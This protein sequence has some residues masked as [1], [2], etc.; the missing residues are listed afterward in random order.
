MPQKWVVRQRQ[1]HQLVRA[2]AGHVFSKEHVTPKQLYG[3]TKL[4][5]ITTSHEGEN[6]KYIERTKIPGLSD[7][8]GTDLNGLSLDDAAIQCARIMGDSRIKQLVRR[9]TG[10]TNF[11][12]AYRNSAYQWFEGN[13]SEIERLFRSA[14]GASNHQD[15]L[16]LASSIEALPRVPKPNSTDGR[17]RPEYILTPV[18]FTLDP[19]LKFPLI[20]GNEWVNNVLCALDVEDSLV[21]EQFSAMAHLI[22]QDGIQDAAE[23]D[24]VG[25]RMPDEVASFI[26][27]KTRKRSKRIL[28]EKPTGNGKPL[29]LKDES[30]VEAIKKAGGIRQRHLHNKM[31]NELRSALGA[32]DI[33]EGESPECMFD[34][35]VKNYDGEGTDLLVEVK[36]ASDTP[37]V[38]MAIGQ[39]YHYWFNLSDASGECHLAVL[40]PSP[41]DVGVLE[42][43][44]NLDIGFL[45]IND[46][47][48]TTKS[49]WL[50][51]LVDEVS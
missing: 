22:G 25:R 3:I 2:I 32:Y 5:W 44:E 6:P 46:G 34:V 13:H 43:L 15:R 40:L 37:H 47:C 26:Q 1:T 51:H 29:P 23:L 45:C 33:L 39:L 16:H 36:S 8:L 9:H 4:S 35:L 12:N 48:L 20:N 21:S 50:T 42:F 19:D 17:M 11:Y 7:A 27:T 24:Q 18:L 38:R 41:P 10:F 31:T 49:S 28:T 30:D 14:Y